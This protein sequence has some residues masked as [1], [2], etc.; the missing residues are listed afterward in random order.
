MA[1]DEHGYTRTVHSGKAEHASRSSKGSSK[2]SPK[3]SSKQV[4][5]KK[6]SVKKAQEFLTKKGLSY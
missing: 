4:A 3:D 6:A 5:T 1:K 2:D